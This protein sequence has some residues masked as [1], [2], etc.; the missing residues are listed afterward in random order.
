MSSLKNTDE[1]VY[2]PKQEW[3]YKARSGEEGSSL[4]ICKVETHS[5]MGTI[6]HVT[7]RGLNIKNPLQKTGFSDVITHLPFT[8]AA[9]DNS[10]VKVL[11]KNHKLP[12][13]LQEDFQLAYADWAAAFEQGKANILNSTVAETIDYIE[14][15]INSTGE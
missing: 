2:Q 14:S 5:E 9:I 1:S 13:D 7:V 10:V 8:E 3:S 6:V 15:S 12:E 11:S 4:V